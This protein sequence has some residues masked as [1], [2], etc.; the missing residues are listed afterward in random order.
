M[1]LETIHPRFSETNAVGH[2]G[3]TVLPA[4]FEKALDGVYRLFMP[5]LAP[6][7]WKLIVVKFDMAC[8]AE[9]NHVDPV[10]IE[11][12]VRKVGN[13]SF[14]LTQH[15]RQDGKLAATAE[16]TLVHFD[17][18]A[19]KARPIADSVRARLVEHLENEKDLG[20]A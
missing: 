9:I 20:P 18:A 13:S 6:Q 5:Q 17:Y 15:L 7:Q 1:F 14:S 11:T 12:K 19:R 16:T 8:L 3:F 4:W 10:R 2:I